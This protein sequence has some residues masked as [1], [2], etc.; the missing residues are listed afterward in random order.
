MILGA[1]VILTLGVIV[2]NFF[3]TTKQGVVD[4]GSTSTI[5]TE[6]QPTF[7]RGEGP[8]TYTVTKGENLWKIAE[9]Q[10]QSG[11]NWVDIAKANEISNG[12]K[13]AIGQKLTIPDVPSKVSTTESISSSSYKVVK[14]DSLWNISVKT[15]GDGNQW[16]KIAAANNLSHPN[17]IHSG[18]T[19]VLPR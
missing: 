4:S 5:A 6:E 1:L 18:N 14:G 9:K 17:L 11:Y 8:V 16:T 2:V 7:V 3:R 15:Y 12:N 13:L 19:L 10:Y